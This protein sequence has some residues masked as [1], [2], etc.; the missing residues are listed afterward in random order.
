MPTIRLER[1]PRLAYLFGA[2]CIISTCAQ[3]AL[4]QGGA[5]SPDK[6]ARFPDTDIYCGNINGNGASGTFY[7][8]GGVTVEECEAQCLAY[9]NDLPTPESNPC[10]G[11]TLVAQQGGTGT[12]YIKYYNCPGTGGWGY[13]DNAQSGLAG[14]CQQVYE[15]VPT[16]YDYS[17]CQNSDDSSTALP[18]T[19]T[20]RRR[21]VRSLE[22]LAEENSKLCPTP[23]LA[24]PILLGNGTQGAGYEC[25][26]SSELNN[27]G[28][29]N[30][31]CEAIPFAT[32][33]SCSEAVCEVHACEA[34]YVARGAFCVEK[35][36]TRHR[37]KKKSSIVPH[38]QAK[39]EAAPTSASRWLPW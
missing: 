13:N 6:F 38:G 14:G 23:M 31:D 11:Y 9:N 21:M 3:T 36:K 24:C 15:N 2:V 22:L 7:G 30:N 17:Q 10:N 26:S 25:I 29:C 19:A 12:C 32:A 33:V 39:R 20:A 5:G 18:T 1:Q 34:G 27:C 35:S 4:A 28:S 8:T 16:G 37:R